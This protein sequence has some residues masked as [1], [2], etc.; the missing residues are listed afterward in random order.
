M[1]GDE[2]IRSSSS[3]VWR[4]FPPLNIHQLTRKAI[5]RSTIW[6]VHFASNEAAEKLPINSIC[7][8]QFQLGGALKAIFTGDASAP[9]FRSI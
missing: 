9:A 1:K 5:I 7:I 2:E 4:D 3:L 6:A 8:I